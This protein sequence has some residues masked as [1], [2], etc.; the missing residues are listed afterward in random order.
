MKRLL[1]LKKILNYTQQELGL[2]QYCPAYVRDYIVTDIKK[3]NYFYKEMQWRHKNI[4][5]SKVEEELSQ[6]KLH[7]LALHIDFM[8]QVVNVAEVTDSLKQD[9]IEI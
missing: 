3:F 7:D 1:Y 6:D 2:S 9:I 4:D 5:Y 8:M